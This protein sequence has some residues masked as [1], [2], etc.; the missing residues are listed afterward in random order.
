[1]AIENPVGRLNQL[2]RYPDQQIEPWHFGDPYTKRTCLWLRGL[3]PLL[4][5]HLVAETE[6]WLP[7]N[8]SG[9]RRGQRSRPGIVSGGR[10]AS[11][12]FH[13]IAD[14]MAEQWGAV[15]ERAA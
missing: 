12:T 8:S 3:P 11:R 13:G 7:S 10:E 4:A 2:W 15:L 9:F 5:T 1:V 6:P 14:A